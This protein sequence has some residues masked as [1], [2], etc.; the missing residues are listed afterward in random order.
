VLLVLRVLT[1]CGRTV[2]FD[3]EESDW[4]SSIDGWGGG[5]TLSL[6]DSPRS[7]EGDDVEEAG[8]FCILEGETGLLL[9]TG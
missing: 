9:M 3:F 1:D 8:D 5:I 6:L 2:L 4:M 7:T